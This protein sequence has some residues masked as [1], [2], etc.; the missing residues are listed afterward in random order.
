MPLSPDAQPPPSSASFTEE[1]AGY[2]GGTSMDTTSPPLF[3]EKFSDVLFNIWNSNVLSIDQKRH[4]DG[5]YV[6]F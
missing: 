4:T 6:R 2:H 1:G 5:V 3:S